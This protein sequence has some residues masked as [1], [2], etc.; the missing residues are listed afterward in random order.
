MENLIR[1]ARLL[2]VFM[3]EHEAAMVLVAEGEDAGD[4]FLAIKAAV[5]IDGGR[6]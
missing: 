3:G 4:A 2:L 5:V 6:A 1:R